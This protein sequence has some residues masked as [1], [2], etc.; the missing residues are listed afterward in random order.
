M[1]PVGRERPS[2][3]ASLSAWR[4]MA[5]LAASRTRLSAQ[6]DFGSHWSGKSSQKIPS[7]GAT[8][9]MPGVRLMSCA[10]G[11]VRSMARSTSP[12]FSA[13]AR[14]VSSGRLRKTSRLMDG[15]LRQ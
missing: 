1:L 10:V 9:R 6:G 7:S 11:P 4:S 15:G 12:L 5:R 3:S 14:V 8:S 2:V 13:A